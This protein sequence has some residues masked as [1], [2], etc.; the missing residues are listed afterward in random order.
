MIQRRRTFKFGIPWSEATWES[1]S[2]LLDRWKAIGEIAA[3]CT[4]LPRPRW[5]L[6]MTN[7][8]A[9]RHRMCAA[10][11]A[12]LQG[13]HRPQRARCVRF[14]QKSSK[15]HDFHLADFA[16]VWYIFILWTK[17]LLG[18]TAQLQLRPSPDIFRRSI[19]L[20][21]L[22][23]CAADGGFAALRMRHAPCGYTKYIC[24]FQTLSRQKIS[25]RMLLLNHALL[26]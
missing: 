1:R 21:S 24:T 17:N 8:W 10:I 5:G 19:G 13:A 7:L 23:Y 2:T 4:R 20:K 18:N 9:L 26:P 3:A 12:N 22:R 15:N 16:C 25:R 11:I 14:L 6:A